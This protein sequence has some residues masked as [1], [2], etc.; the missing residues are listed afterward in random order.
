[1]R[2]YPYYFILYK[3]RV[4]KRHVRRT[5]YS[6]YTVGTQLRGEGGSKDAARDPRNSGMNAAFSLYLLINEAFYL[7]LLINEAFSL[8]LLMNE[9]FSLY[10][11]MNDAFLFIY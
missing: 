8:Y 10:L 9:A 7:Y 6:P 1:M 11:L 3:L 2:A 4:Q 5:F